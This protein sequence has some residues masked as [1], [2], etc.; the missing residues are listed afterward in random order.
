MDSTSHVYFAYRLH[1]V[2]KTQTQAL[3][4]SLF[5][6]VDRQPPYFHRLYAHSVAQIPILGPLG[7]AIVWNHDSGHTPPT[8]TTNIHTR[9]S[10]E[11]NRFL[12]YSSLVSKA[13]SGSTISSE[14]PDYLSTVISYLS[15]IYL[16]TFNNPVQAFTPNIPHVCCQMSL[17]KQLDPIAFRVNLYAPSTI[18]R[19]H[20]DMFLNGEWDQSIEP[21]ALVHALIQKTADTCMESLDNN[22]ITRV[23]QYLHIGDLPTLEERTVALDFLRELEDKIIALTIQLSQ[24]PPTEERFRVPLPPLM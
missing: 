12:S 2:S 11:K 13:F 23:Y 10:E 19:F 4:C 9:F 6:Q 20:R 8:P 16:D 17:W 5:P 21:H 15:H 24:N 14:P 22:F 7:V 3:V 1:Q 18:A